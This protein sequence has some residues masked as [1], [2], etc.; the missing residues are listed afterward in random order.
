MKIK[1][2]GWGDSMVATKYVYQRI[3]SILDLDNA[4]DAYYHLSRLMEELA[5]N[6]KVDTGNLIGAK[7]ENND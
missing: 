5:I 3:H 6:Y 4:D 1:T 7:N 2:N